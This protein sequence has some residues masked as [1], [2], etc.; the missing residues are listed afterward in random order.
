VA[1]GADRVVKT[2]AALSAVTR[3]LVVL[4]T[5]EGVLSASAD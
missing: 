2:V 1:N 3:D 4:N 5:R